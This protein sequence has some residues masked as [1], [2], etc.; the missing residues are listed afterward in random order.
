[1]KPEQS[2]IYQIS[3]APKPPPAPHHVTGESKAA[4]SDSEEPG[5]I[6]LTSNL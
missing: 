5:N 4:V 3:R 6:S 2:E 1:M